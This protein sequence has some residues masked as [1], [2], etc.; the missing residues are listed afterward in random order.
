MVKAVYVRVNGEEVKVWDKD[1]G[2]LD[3]ELFKRVAEVVENS[4]IPEEESK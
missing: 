4:D 3:T 1:S 2:V